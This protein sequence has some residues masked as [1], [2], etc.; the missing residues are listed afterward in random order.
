MRNVFSPLKS[1]K[2]PIIIAYCLTFVELAVELLL[3]FF[4]GLMINNGVIEEDI[5]N[6]MMWGSI[7]IGLAFAGFVAGIINSFYSS[8]VSFAF[9]YDIR[10]KL[11]EKIQAF[12]FK[13][14]NQYPTS[15]LVTRFTNDVRQIQNTIFMALRIMAKAPLIVLGGV[16]M[17]FVVNARLALI[18]VVTVPLLILFL[19]WVLKVAS[20][21]FD[22][23]QRN[24][25]NVN[26]VM[27]ENLA[28]M[29][30]IKAFLRR[31][32]EENRFTKANGDLANITR[33]TF[34]FVEA[35]MP[36]LLFIMNL[37]L[38]FII[39]FGNVQSIAGETSVGEVVTIVNYAL[40]VSMAIS[41]FT[42][43]I[44]AFSRTKAS[45]SRI[46][47]VL[48][49]DVDL[50]DHQDADK[51][52][53]VTKGKIEYQ[54]VS[55][56]YPGTNKTVLKD[57]SFNVDAGEK[58]AIIG[59][60]GTGKT[61]LFQLVPRLY[62]I[63]QGEILIDSKPVSSYILDQLRGSIGYVPQ[64]PL[65]FTG[66]ITDNIAWGKNGATT[67]EIIQAAKDAQ[68]HDTIMGLSHQYD[69]KVGQKGVNLSG[70]QKQRISI[71]RALIRR[72][73]ILMLDDSTSALDLAT[74][75]RLLT[76]IQDYDCTTLIITQK[77]STAISADRILLM[78]DGKVL[79]MGTHEELLKKSDLY[80]EIVES[81]FGKEYAYAR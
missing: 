2:L 77:I 6:I 40:R 19:L 48:T 17:A 46:S 58:L 15:G 36:I 50:V 27:Q 73:K 60:T 13:N 37:S 24:V 63:N 5:N 52:A 47:E 66:S 61:S 78:D 9:G 45:A 44:L 3:P 10:Q 79:A 68:I 54:N 33:T 69:T 34:R 43:I 39:W 29:R 59:A 76:A 18:F 21:M 8:H 32:H 65:L 35:S 7:M 41:M 56:A 62:D 11:F 80:R 30:L 20:K 31:N 28:G 71:A 57:I 42:F 1:Y 14:L 25:D 74:E 4:L 70:G 72:P 53:V 12:S 51:Q 64:S 26:R 81:Q 55:F 75:S 67:D 49:L 16:I 38:I 22:K 23:V